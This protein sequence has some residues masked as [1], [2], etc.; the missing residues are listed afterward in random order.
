MSHRCRALHT[1][2]VVLLPRLPH[3]P[4]A[5]LWC[6][7]S[8]SLQQTKLPRTSV[9]HFLCDNSICSQHD[10]TQDNTR[11]L[12]VPSAAALG[13]KGVPRSALLGDCCFS[14]IMV[15]LSFC[16]AQIRLSLVLQLLTGSRRDA[17]SNRGS[18]CCGM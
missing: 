1:F 10:T 7:R 8:S 18:I 14:R 16:N 11:L 5:P 15:K 17:V 13:W 2:I 4:M 3:R 12:A 9:G 6:Q